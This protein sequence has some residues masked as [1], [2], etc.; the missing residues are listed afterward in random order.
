MKLCGRLHAQLRLSQQPLLPQSSLQQSSQQPSSRQLSSVTAEA[1]WSSCH[2]CARIRSIMQA[3]LR[4]WQ[5]R[6][7]LNAAAAQAPA[8]HP[9]HRLSSASHVV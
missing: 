5:H 7:P 6:W 8:R 9:P 1:A 3:S 4:P 2:Q